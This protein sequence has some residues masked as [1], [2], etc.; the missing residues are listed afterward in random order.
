MSTSRCTKLWM[1]PN[2][3][4]GVKECTRHI[5]ALTTG[6]W[7]STADTTCVE[8]ALRDVATP[9]IQP[10]LVWSVVE[11]IPVQ[12]TYIEAGAVLS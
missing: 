10:I 5:D 1:Q 6:Q 8:A 4:A 9:I 11:K 7:A 3:V 2:K 12:L